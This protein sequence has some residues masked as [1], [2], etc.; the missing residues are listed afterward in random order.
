MGLSFE[1]QKDATIIIITINIVKKM[2]QLLK[3]L[4]S[5]M[6][7]WKDTIFQMLY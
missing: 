7:I 3:K 4:F 2:T 6:V 1:R 5:E